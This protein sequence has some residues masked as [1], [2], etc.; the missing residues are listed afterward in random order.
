MLVAFRGQ[1]Y[2]VEVKN[3][4]AIPAKHL[5]TPQAKRAY[6]VKMLTKGERD[7]MD[8]LSANHVTYH[9]WTGIEDAKD[10]LF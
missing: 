7:C 6:L 4:E 2:L 10:A 1:V 3:P 9:I 8:A 5:E